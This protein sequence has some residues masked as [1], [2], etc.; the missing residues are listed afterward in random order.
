MG[1]GETREENRGAAATVLVVHAGERKLEGVVHQ[2][3]P[4]HKIE[5]HAQKDADGQG[6]KR[7][8]EKPQQ[9]RCVGKEWLPPK[10]PL[11]GQRKWIISSFRNLETL[12]F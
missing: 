12:K 8:A 9:E 5:D 11:M 7:L 4:R 2:A 10:G 3:E 1:R 6:W